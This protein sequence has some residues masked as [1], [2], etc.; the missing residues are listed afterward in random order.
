ML[1]TARKLRRKIRTD[2]DL[3]IDIKLVPFRLYT[4]LIDLSFNSVPRQLFLSS[5]RLLLRF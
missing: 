2:H 3:S 4:Y 1:K 5:N